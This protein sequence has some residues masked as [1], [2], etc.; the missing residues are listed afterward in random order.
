MRTRLYIE[1]SNFGNDPTKIHITV[2]GEK[3]KTI[4]TDGKSIYCMVPSKAFDGTIN[5][6]IDG[7]DG[8]TIAEHTFEQEFKYDPATIVGTLLRKVDQDNNSAF[9]EGSFD[10]GASI[11]SNDCMV[12]DP[13]YK[14]GDDRLL[15][16]S[17]FY[18]GIHLVNLTQRTVKRLFP[19]TGYSTMYSFTFS[20]DGDT[21]LFTDDHGQD[22]TTRANIYYSLRRENF[23]RI[24]P[25]NYGKTSYSLIYMDDGTVF[26]TTWWEGKVYKMVRN[27]AIPNIDNNA[28]VTFSLSQISSVDGSHTILFRHPSNKFMYMLSDGF[29]AVFRADYD[30][31]KKHSVILP[32]LPET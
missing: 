24:R 18:D 16:S 15:F 5:V 1:G 17:N 29:G 8:K 25:Y 21:L 14:E 32:S 9:Q 3:T 31:V 11:P 27:G 28:E 12:F 30:P 4:G 20:A 7:P 23:R 10:E 19:R 6:S 2:G 13:K 22:N 26:Y